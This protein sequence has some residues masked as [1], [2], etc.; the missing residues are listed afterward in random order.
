MK[1]KTEIKSSKESQSKRLKKHVKGQIHKKGGE[2]GD[3]AK[4]PPLIEAIL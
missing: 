2:K 1:N 4:N 3:F